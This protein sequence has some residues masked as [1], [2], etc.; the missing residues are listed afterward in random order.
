MPVVS[1]LPLAVGVACSMRIPARHGHRCGFNLV[2]VG[3]YLATLADRVGEDTAE[4]RE[5][6]KR[7]AHRKER[8]DAAGWRYVNEWL[9]ATTPGRSGT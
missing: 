9:S 5:L 4:L 6:M 2:K 8:K 3:A 7:A 1:C